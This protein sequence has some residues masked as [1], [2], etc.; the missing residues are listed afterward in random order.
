MKLANRNFLNF[1]DFLGLRIGFTIYTAWVLAATIIGVASFLKSAGLLNKIF[2]ET[3][4]TCILLWIAFIIYN[5]TTYVEKNP[6]FGA[7]FIWVLFG[8]YVK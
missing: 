1:W 8:I 6:L 4:W 2:A 3:T 5:V 7:V